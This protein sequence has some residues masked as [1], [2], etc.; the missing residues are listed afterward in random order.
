MLFNLRNS[1]QIIK[2]FVNEVLDKLDFC[3]AHIEDKLV[4][5]KNKKEHVD[6]LRQVFGWTIKVYIP[7]IDILS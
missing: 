3:Y 6:H 4:F 7:R 1:A 5:S 2:K